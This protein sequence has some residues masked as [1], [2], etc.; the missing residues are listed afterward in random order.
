MLRVAAL[1]AA[2]AAAAVR[3]G[4]ASIPNGAAQADVLVAASAT[5]SDSDSSDV[6]TTLLN[7]RTTLTFA[8]LGPQPLDTD[9]PRVPESGT[10]LRSKLEADLAD[11][12]FEFMDEQA[13]TSRTFNGVTQ[14]DVVSIEN[15]QMDSHASSPVRYAFVEVGMEAEF[16]IDPSCV[17]AHE[18][19]N[20]DACAQSADAIADVLDGAS[21][22]L[23]SALHEYDMELK[24]SESGDD[25]FSH[26]DPRA[27]DFELLLGGRPMSSAQLRIR[28]K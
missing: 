12:L 18:L 1:L 23:H 27:D 13:F 7:L 6:A 10:E 16:Q 3:C 28:A 19:R 25:G 9:L 20:S 21:A 26:A 15:G 14:I 24:F 11:R 22:L 2:V 5:V 8:A 17:R 4:S